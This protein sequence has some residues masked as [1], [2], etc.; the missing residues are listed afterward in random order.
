[1]STKFSRRR[2]AVVLS[3]AAAT[4]FSVALVAV[5]V[6]YT[7]SGDGLN[8]VWNL[9]LAWIPLLLAV[10]VYDGYRRGAPR[11]GLLAGAALWL[12]FFPNAPYIL[13]DFKW[14]ADWSGTPVVFDVLVV[15]AAAATGLALGFV[16]LYLMQ[17]LACRL[18]G[19]LTS[20]LLVVAFLGLSSFGVYLGRVQRWNSWDVFAQPVSLLS[21]IG[22]GLSDP[23]SHGR[24]LAGTTLFTVLLTLAYAAFYGV[25]RLR[26]SDE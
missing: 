23:L 7:G 6:A 24:M 17:A 4:F 2:I 3:L 25:T 12:L 22:E 18:F 1:M 9:T 15:G 5:R 10:L 20:W 13:T 16:S 19:R 8:L 21:D 11:P 26:L 14:I